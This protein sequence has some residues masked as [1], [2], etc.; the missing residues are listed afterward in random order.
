LIE[1]GKVVISIAILDILS[2]DGQREWM[3]LTP[4]KKHNDELKK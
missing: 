3:L 2:G 1:R 4:F